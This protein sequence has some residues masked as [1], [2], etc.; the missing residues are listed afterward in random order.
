VTEQDLY[1]HAVHAWPV[2]VGR[3]DEMRDRLLRLTNLH[4]GNGATP[5]SCTECGMPAPCRT[6]L[7]AAG[8]R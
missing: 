5:P 2:G 4:G 8:L 7:I 3:A 6:A 1:D